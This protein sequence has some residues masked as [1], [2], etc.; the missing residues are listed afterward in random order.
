MKVYISLDVEFSK[1]QVDELAVAPLLLNWTLV[2]PLSDLWLRS[3]VVLGF[4]SKYRCLT[5]FI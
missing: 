1:L 4:Q 2:I 3:I 5:V